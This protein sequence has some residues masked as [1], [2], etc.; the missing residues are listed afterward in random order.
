MHLAE[1]PEP[2]HGRETWRQG[3]ELMKHA[4]PDPEAHVDD[5]VAAD[6]IVAVRVSL[7]GTAPLPGPALQVAELERRAS[8]WRAA[9][10]S[11][12]ST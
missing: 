2:L 8:S 12:L 7:R 9:R 6:D 4:F 5:V 11:E 10:L 1:L 3:F